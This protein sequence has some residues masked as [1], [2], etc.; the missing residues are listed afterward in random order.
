MTRFHSFYSW[1][2]FPLVSMAHFL[3]PVIHQR[4]PGWF[5]VLALVDTAA[6]NMGVR[7]VFSI[8]ASSLLDIYSGVG[9][10]AHM[11]VLVPVFWGALYQQCL[12]GPPFLHPRQHLMF[13]AFLITAILTRVR[14][15][16]VVLICISLM[17]SD[18]EQISCI[19]WIF[20]ILF[21]KHP[22]KS[23]THF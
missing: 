16:I 15:F 21:Q 1:I 18:V 12:R 11:T 2:V 22:F 19:C 17:L 13:S 8:P 23:F 20:Y 14:Y 10:L 6:V 5:C 3:D 9:L 4:Y 7:C